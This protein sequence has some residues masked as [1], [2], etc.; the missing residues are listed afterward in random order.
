MFK[1]CPQRVIDMEP[2][3]VCTLWMYKGDI[4]RGASV[5]RRTH[6]MLLDRGDR[7]FSLDGL[8]RTILSANRF[9]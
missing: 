2:D 3:A 8:G 1:P 7:G 6:A 5:M 4:R 9:V